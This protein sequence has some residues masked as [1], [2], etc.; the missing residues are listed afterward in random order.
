VIEAYFLE[1]KPSEEIARDLGITQSR[2][3]QLRTDALEM[4]REGLEAQDAPR[5]AERPVGRV[6][7][8][9]SRYATAIARQSTWQA[10]VSF[11]DH[12]SESLRSGLAI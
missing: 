11:S 3:S 6:A 8:R 9:K 7:R 1:G 5:P 10:R 4:M 2:V 12:T